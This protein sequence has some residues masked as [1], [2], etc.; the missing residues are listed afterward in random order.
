MA[1]ADSN[2]GNGKDA[3][4]A[5]TAADAAKRVRRPVIA[6]VDEKDKDGNAIKVPKVVKH[7]PVA[8][9]EVL[10]FKDYGDYVNVVTKD[11][12]KFTDGADA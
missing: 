11:G 3:V 12:Q 7:V 2:A 1:T 6:L 9:D 8:T 10:A 5:M 4:K